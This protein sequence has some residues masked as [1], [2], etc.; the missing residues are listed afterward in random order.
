MSKADKL[1]DWLNTTRLFEMAH[2][3]SEVISR[4]KNFQYQIF[5]HLLKLLAS[6]NA[7]RKHWATEVNTFLFDLQD[8]KSKSS[9]ISESEWL[10]YLWDEPAGHGP[11][12]IRTNWLSILNKEELARNNLSDR[13]VWTQMKSLYISVCHDLGIRQFVGIQKY[14]EI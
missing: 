3:R 1:L 9:D 8:L 10:K 13:E 12:S 6:S 11:E 7:Y 5:R 2:R 4:I 14:L